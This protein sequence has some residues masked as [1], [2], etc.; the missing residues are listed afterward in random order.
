VRGTSADSQGFVDIALVVDGKP[1]D[2]CFQPV[3]ADPF[4]AWSM[5][6]SFQLTAGDHSIEAQ[7]ES[8]LQQ[9]AAASGDAN[10]FF[11]GALT[12]VTIKK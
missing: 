7:S 9:P 2:G 10:D 8:P 12:V 5:A 3:N 11:Q 6:R 4:D 1:V